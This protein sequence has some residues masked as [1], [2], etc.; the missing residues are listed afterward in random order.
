VLTFFANSGRGGSGDFSDCRLV[1]W[2][3]LL[4]RWARGDA[5]IVNADLAGLTVLAGQ[6]AK[7]RRRSWTG[8][9]VTSES[10]GDENKKSDGSVE[11]HLDLFDCGLAF[12]QHKLMVS[13]MRDSGEN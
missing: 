1:M 2:R 10:W 11:N 8:W 12:F 3:R 5:Y 9:R 4:R 6:T 13:S 7:P